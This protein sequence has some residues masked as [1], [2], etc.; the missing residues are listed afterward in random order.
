MTTANPPGED[1][2]VVP[3]AD[4][5]DEAQWV[6][7]HI[8]D[9]AAGQWNEC[10]ILYRCNAQALALESA[11]FE[12][13]IPFT[14]L[15]GKPFFELSEVKLLLAYLR[16]ARNP[17]DDAALKAAINIPP[18]YLG[19]EF[20]NALQTAATEGETHL[21][22]AM[23]FMQY[24]RNFQRQKAMEFKQLVENLR[25][26]NRT[27]GPGQ[28][29]R[30]VRGPGGFDAWLTAESDDEPDNERA[31]NVDELCRVS[32]RWTNTGEFLQHVM[33]VTKASKGKGNRVSLLTMHRAKGLEWPRV[34][35]TG[36]C[37]GV[38]PHEKATW[39]PGGEEEERRLFY[40]GMTRAMKTLN[41]Y[42]PDRM[43]RRPTQPSRF[44]YE[45]GIIVE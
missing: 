27:R 44:L 43:W 29:L 16:L 45:A 36:M 24:P 39:A 23:D 32:E 31:R 5:D 25:H 10:A 15:G 42:V 11:L 13:E 35:I 2:G 37:E 7:R 8:A 9:R 21:Y 1:V 22:Q 14:V 40:V 28:L 4:S 18:R 26:L 20:Q 3:C 34:S 12:A 41:I 33:A 38:C 30:E 6:A 19:P 17:M